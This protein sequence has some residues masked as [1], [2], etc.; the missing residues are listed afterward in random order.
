MIKKA[1][2][3]LIVLAL[4][5]SSLPIISV[6]AAGTS[7][8]GGL[9]HFDEGTGGIT[10]DSTGNGNTATI[11]GASWT[12]GRMGEAL[13][14]DG[15]DDYVEVADSNSLDITGKLTLEAW[16]FPRSYIGK[17]VIVCKYNHSSLSS[18]YYLSLGGTLGATDY[19]DRIYF[20]LTYNGNNY[21]PMVSNAVIPLNTW[22][23]VAA[24]SNATHMSIYLNG[25]RDKTRTYPPGTIYAGTAD[26][27]IGCYLPEVGYARCFDGV[28]DEVRV[29]EGTIWTVDD[30][31]VQCP[32]A[33]FAS[34]QAA[35]NAAA[36]E[37]TIIVHDGTYVENVN[38]DK[39]LTLK[40]A[41]KPIIDGSQAGP[42]ITI[43]ADGVTVEGF[44]LRNGAY[45]IASWGTDH[46]VIS[47]NVIH[48]IINE[49]SY[50][51]C[52]IMFWSDTDDFDNNVI[53]YNEIFHCDRQGIYIGG[54]TDAY[55]SEE[56]QVVGNTIYNNGL[57]THPN[58]P[59]ASAYG[60]QLSY[61]DHN[62][63]EGN[64]IYGHVDWFYYP[65]FDFAQGVYLFDSNHN[66]IT[67]N[68]LCDNNYG[69]GLYHYGRAV[70]TNYINYNN[71]AGNTGYG[72][73]TFDG[74]PAVDAKFNW[75]GDSSGPTHASNSGGTGDV[76]S[77]NVDY[78]PWLGAVFETVPRTYH[79]N[80]TGTIQEA[81][82]EASSGDT[83]AIHDGTYEGALY[84]NKNLTIKAASA[85][86]ITGSQLFATDFGNREAVIFV[87]NAADV[88]LEGFDVEGS[89]LGPVKSCGI[90]YENSGGTVRQC[91]V[92]PNTVGD[93]NST[94]IA[95]W[96]NSNLR[97]ENCTIHDFGRI[98]IY[99]NN[100]TMT[101]VDN[102]VVGQV[103]SLD[104]QV[105]YGIEIEDYSGPSIASI[106]GNE[107]YDCSNTNPNPMW[108]S[109][110]IIVD[111]WRE[112]A[113]Y[114]NI[115][116]LPSKVSITYNTIHDNYEA[117]EI[118]SNEFSYA[119]YNSFSDNLYGV[120][121][122]PENWTTNPT[123]YVFDACYNWWG[124]A[125]G[126]YHETSWMY[127][128]QPYGP[129]YGS[130]E[131]V[132]DYVLYYPWLNAPS[133]DPV[134]PPT[135]SFTCT[136][137][138][139]KM[140]EEAV[141]DASGSSANGGTITEYL[142]DFGDGNINSTV[143]PLV[144]HGFD[145]TGTYNV[146]LTVTDS[147]GLSDSTWQ[148]VNVIPALFH[149][150]AVIDVTASP[151]QAYQGWL[152]GID[153]TVANLGEAA[154]NFTVTVYYDGNVI[155]SQ[156]VHLEPN[157]TSVLSFVW[158]TTGVPYC[159]NYTISAYATPVPYE[160]E[161]TNNT[162]IDGGVKIRIAGDTN[163]DGTIDYRDINHAAM[164]F[165]ST[166]ASPRWNPYCDLDRDGLIDMKDIH[167][168]ARR[169][170][171]TC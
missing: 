156:S 166:A 150:V 71:I 105:N 164:A 102:K 103:Y 46:T 128:G 106:E 89:G 66:T 74:S 81:I 129:H 124:D 101:I 96:S 43:S 92:S 42:C 1:I 85:P 99:S 64:D 3:L 123:Y 69:V 162:Y 70:E 153:V 126:P 56:N 111:T 131:S 165:G 154:E 30:D 120:W 86:V 140:G 143:D 91:V 27:R 139:P 10:Y 63:I 17:Q 78:S 145:S 125:S 115:A 169:F 94:G 158:N 28:I 24:T 44:E 16:I 98:G 148:T 83:I 93:M 134:E 137:A 157:A 59:D 51:G 90:L 38:I 25:V 171:Q 155:A 45:G 39:P 100:A 117:I 58:L 49:P 160:T 60:I 130:G 47:N 15:V 159:H 62:T 48:D 163:G 88:M 107:I 34:I 13:D 72:V 50:A 114:Y 33:D 53:S 2:A 122:A 8:L 97:I 112:W 12:N 110:A 11:T 167:T 116:L 135:A 4:L 40:S 73:R 132:S 149:D 37:D 121:S 31:N 19:P 136:P 6:E 161:L 133:G 52:G 21:Y 168:V 32:N 151:D 5:T 138:E 61:A 14:F 170:G 144:M 41:S 147:E 18:S 82:D 22:T 108:S 146:T 75:W 95:A 76:I 7:C 87:E 36:P 35:V 119:H 141:F 79:V 104:N 109:A 57:Y 67:D 9:W 54:T 55:I 152:V 26:L 113:D 127:M 29:A 118:V 65:E 20:G 23:H 142:W 68:Y 80:P 84:I 77:D